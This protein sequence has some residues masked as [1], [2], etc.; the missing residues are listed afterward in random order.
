MKR[1]VYILFCIAAFSSCLKGVLDKQPLDA[2]SDAV[3]WNDQALIDAYLTQAYLQ[4]YI[5]TN[6]TPNA[7]WASS[8]DWNGPF[9]VNELSDECMRNW[10]VGQSQAK[11]NGITITGGVLDWWEHAYTVI[12]TL[13]EFIKRVPAAPVDEHFRKVRTAEARFL[14]AYNYFAMVKRYGGVPLITEPQDI[15]ASYDELYRKRDKEQ[16]VYDFVLSEM[17]AIV[18]ELP[19]RS[20]TEYGR[21]S[22]YTALALKCRAALYAASIAQYGTV[23]LQGL[24]GISAAPDGYYQQAYDAAAQIMQSHQYALYNA[25]GD[26][27]VNFKNVFLQKNNPEVI[28]A[29]RHDYVQRN[30][31]GNGWVWDFFQA[32]KPHAWNAGNQNAPYLEMAEAYEHVDGTPGTLDRTAIQQGL[33]SMEELWADKDPRFYATIYTQGTPWK[34]SAVDFH[35]G[36]LLP[37]GTVQNSGSYQN[38]PAKGVQSVDNSFGTGFGVMKYLE[39]SKDNMSERATSGTD[40]QLFR[41]AEILLNYAEAAFELGKA[42]EA[43]AAV[44]Q[45]RERAGIAAL[46]SISREKIRQERKVELAFEGHRYWDLRRW[47]VAVDLLSVNRSGLRYI[48]D[49]ASGKY[50]LEVTEH[51]DGA[52]SNPV[53]YERNYYLPLTTARTGNNPNLVENPGYH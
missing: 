18:N 27:V 50:R 13:N 16:Q 40:W 44:N 23:E 17:D 45:V 43:L 30:T 20:S 37:D 39:E 26:K 52:T 24:T 1:T 32:P 46:T 42:G 48:L 7:D 33:W 15:N 53:F 12:R 41:Y 6:E 38:V 29:K 14:R 5:L 8:D 51:I 2:I 35:N 21:P 31:G 10:V 19:D 9:I 49:F 47:R 25:D 4:M 3:V 28:W 36:L 34:G 22:K 11:T